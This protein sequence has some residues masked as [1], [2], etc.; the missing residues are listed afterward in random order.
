MFPEEL[1]KVNLE[2]LRKRI[3]KLEGQR[4]PASELDPG[5][6]AWWEYW[7]PIV[8]RI[9]DGEP[10]QLTIEAFRVLADIADSSQSPQGD[11]GPISATSEL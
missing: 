3:E 7:G 1:Q 4:V 2:H 10:G 8:R 11:A 9:L 5:S 6:A